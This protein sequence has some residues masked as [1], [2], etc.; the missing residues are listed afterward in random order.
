MTAKEYLQQMYWIN[1]EVESRLE[2]ISRLQ[3]LATRTTT[4][5]KSTPS[6]GT[7]LSSRVESAVVDI[8][9]QADDLAEQ[10]KEFLA[11]S[12][13]ISAAIAELEN[14]DERIILEYRYLCFYKWQEIAQKLNTGLRHIFKLHSRALKNFSALFTKCH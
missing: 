8:Q 9:K 14:H 11:I 12:K 13:G 5:L 1:G 3:S 6:G 2:Q 7:K 10:I 4:V